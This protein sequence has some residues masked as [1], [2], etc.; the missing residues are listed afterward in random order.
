[1]KTSNE[2]G[3][4]SLSPDSKGNA[5]YTSRLTQ[6]FASFFCR[7]FLSIPCL[8]KVAVVL[9]V[10]EWMFNLLTCFWDFLMFKPI[11]SW[12]KPYFVFCIIFT[13][14]NFLISF[15][16]NYTFIKLMKTFG[17]FIVLCNEDLLGTIVNDIVRNKAVQTSLK[18]LKAHILFWVIWI[19][20]YL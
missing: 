4:L 8:L 19:W 3:Y 20:F 10:N 16:L 12:D 14:I 2:S 6:V 7:N 18:V 15:Q 11:F 17:I 9:V 13:G 1:M 5:F